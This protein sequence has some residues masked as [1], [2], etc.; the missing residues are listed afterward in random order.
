MKYGLVAKGD[1]VF[2]VYREQKQ[3]LFCYALLHPFLHSVFEIHFS[4]KQKDEI[5]PSLC[6]I[7]QRTTWEVTY[8]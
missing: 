8:F 5:V 1:N 6:Y 4:F 2:A 3:H 7:Q